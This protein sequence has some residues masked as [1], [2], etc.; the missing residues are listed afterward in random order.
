MPNGEARVVIVVAFKKNAEQNTVFFLD[1]KKY[2]IPACLR[3]ETCP[4]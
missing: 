3:K 4:P 1:S 2:R